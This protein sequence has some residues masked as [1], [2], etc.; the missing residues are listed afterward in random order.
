MISKRGKI[1]RLRRMLLRQRLFFIQ[2]G[3]RIGLDR[4]IDTM[5]EKHVM[6]KYDAVINNPEYTQLL[7]DIVD[8][9]EAP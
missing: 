3:P 8:L 5:I 1:E 6:G 9:I 4:V 7:R 2:A